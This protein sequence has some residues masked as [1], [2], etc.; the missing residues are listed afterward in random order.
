M[1]RRALLGSLAAGV[2]PLLAGCSGSRIDGEVLESDTPL[3]L[4]HEHSTQATPSG[5]RIVVDVTAEND[6][7]EP[8]TPEAPVPRVVCT[9]FDSA[10][11]SLYESSL[12]LPETVDVGETVSFE[13]TLA[14]DVD[15]AAGYALRSEWVQP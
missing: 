14:V 10:D 9:F 12:K 5:T 6:G 13:F 3:R 15:D 7:E 11:Q 4:S 1:H 8:I 2:G